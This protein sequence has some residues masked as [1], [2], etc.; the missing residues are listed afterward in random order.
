MWLFQEHLRDAGSTLGT[1]L[2]GLVLTALL[3][4]VL[5]SADTILNTISAFTTQSM[6]A[7]RLLEGESIIAAVVVNFL[8]TCFSLVLALW[9]REVVGLITEGF[10][11]L[12]LL[13]PSIVAAIIL[14]RPNA[15]AATFSL[16]AGAAAY[17]ITKFASKATNEWAY[18]FGFV[19][20]LMSL[21]LVYQVEKGEPLTRGESSG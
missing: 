9:A 15:R 6:K 10:K 8:I 17:V 3:C 1:V 19:A 4:A 16:V 2:Y 20:A 21:L 13:L 12:T 18:V 5:S 11:A 14:R 7:W